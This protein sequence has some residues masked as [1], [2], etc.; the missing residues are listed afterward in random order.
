MCKSTNNANAQ[1]RAPV[2]RSSL[3]VYKDQLSLLAQIEDIERR[4]IP[5]LRTQ[6]LEQ[7]NLAQNRPGNLIQVTTLQQRLQQAE[8]HLA[9]LKKRLSKLVE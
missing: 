4:L 3:A 1:S 8:C 9:E 7:A 2:M 5:T 6:Y